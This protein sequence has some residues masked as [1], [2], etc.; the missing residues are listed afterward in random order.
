MVMSMVQEFL[1]SGVIV[2]NSLPASRALVV[3]LV[4]GVIVV[5]LAFASEPKEIQS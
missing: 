5:G 4:V 3:V 2:C 1:G